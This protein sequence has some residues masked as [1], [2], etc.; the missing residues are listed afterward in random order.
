MKIVNHEAYINGLKLCNKG[1]HTLRENSLGI[2]FCT[3]CGLLS[4]S[5]NTER[6]KEEDKIYVKK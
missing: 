6:L 1:K 5:T 3:R 4:N 2:V